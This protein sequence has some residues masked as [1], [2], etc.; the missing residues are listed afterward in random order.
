[1]ARSKACEI[2]PWAGTFFTLTSKKCSVADELKDTLTATTHQN[3]N[4]FKSLHLEIWIFIW[5]TVYDPPCVFVVLKLY[6]R[7]SRIKIEWLYRQMPT[8]K[9]LEVSL[10]VCRD[11]FS[12]FILGKADEGQ[13]VS[14]HLGESIF[15]IRPINSEN[16]WLPE[17]SGS[18]DRK[19]GPRGVWDTDRILVIEWISHSDKSTEYKIQSMI[20]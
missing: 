17:R 14:I 6:G 12:K 11:L 16:R 4:K 2:C 1:M 8:N 9:S 7:F 15:R 18:K 3:F 10:Y 5:T 19:K 20:L 13:G